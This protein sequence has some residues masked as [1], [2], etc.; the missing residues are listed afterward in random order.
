MIIPKAPCSAERNCPARSDSPRAIKGLCHALPRFRT[1]D[2]DAERHAY[3]LATTILKRDGKACAREHL[4][5]A[6]KDELEMAADGECR[7]CA[8]TS[9]RDVSYRFGAMLDWA[10][11]SLRNL[12]SGQSSLG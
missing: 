3:A 1:G 10:G 2:D 7:R 12:W 4:M 9:T 8:C 11:Y 5:P 6:I